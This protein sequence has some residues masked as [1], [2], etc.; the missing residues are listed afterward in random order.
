M[1][2]IKDNIYWVGARDWNVRNFHGY[3]T[4]QGT[5]YNAFLICDEKIT[6][7]D[8]VKKSHCEEMLAR[9]KKIIDPSQIDLI[10]CN[11]VEMDHSGSL[12]ELIKIAPNAQIIASPIGLKGLNDH[13]D[14]S[15]W[16][17]KTVKANEEINIG[18][19]TLRFVPI[20]FVHWPDSMLTY[21]PEEK[22]LMPN[23]AFGQHLA[24]NC[25]F[26]DQAPLD[27]VFDQA[28]KYYANII[29]PLG[30]HVCKILP[31][32]NAMEI[33]MIAPSHGLI[34]RN[35]IDQI[36]EKYIRW[37][38]HQSDKKAVIVYDSM[39]ESTEKIAQQIMLELDH[40]QIPTTMRS[41]KY[42][43]IS[44]I[45]NDMLEAKYVLIGSSILNNNVLPTVGSFL[46]Y[47][48]GLRPENKV[49]MVFGSYGWNAGGLTEIETLMK[50]LSW[51]LPLPILSNK[52]QPKE[53]VLRALPEQLL[54]LINSD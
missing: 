6:L 20:P 31:L 25:L 29:W 23:D 27:I 45:V 17:I 18:K 15:S 37:A 26:A 47:L 12:P 8:T 43:H 35:H 53:D 39:W 33:E 38:N 28:A 3:K 24:Y 50:D 44:D 16:N 48:R 2:Q 22:L 1:N 5:S 14:T 51:K 4:Q 49:G 32:L 11:H 34:W 7:V 42:S 9:I 54:K 46:T 36:V 30:K 21:I 19:R 41:L 40:L 10:I 13:Y 52:Y